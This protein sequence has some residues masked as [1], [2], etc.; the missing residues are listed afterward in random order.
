MSMESLCSISDDKS[1]FQQNR[2]KFGFS[3]F[4]YNSKMLQKQ[5][6]S[7]LKCV[8]FQV[9]KFS[10]E[11]SHENISSL[12][13]IYVNGGG[14]KDERGRK[15]EK[16]GRGFGRLPSF[17]PPFLFVVSG[18]FLVVILVQIWLCFCVLR[19]RLVSNC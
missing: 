12:N 2:T 3:F 19:I 9:F 6:L 1:I 13:F 14:N 7:C 17:F 5:T 18:F 4:Q 11:F 10:A 8:R 15:N 16:G